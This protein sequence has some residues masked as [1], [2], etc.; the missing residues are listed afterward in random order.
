MPKPLGPARAHGR[1]IAQRLRHA[2]RALLRPASRDHPRRWLGTSAQKAG[3]GAS[4]IC[5][6]PECQTRRVRQRIKLAASFPKAAHLTR[7]RHATGSKV[8]KHLDRFR[9]LVI[10]RTRCSHRTS[11]ALRTHLGQGDRARRG[12]TRSTPLCLHDTVLLRRPKN[13]V[14]RIRK[15]HG[16]LQV[17]ATTTTSPTSTTSA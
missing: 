16:R 15:K 12:F 1:L 14:L 7:N 17:C 13:P 10:S 2:M 8:Q 11:F 4:C 6:W 9:T 5:V 3:S